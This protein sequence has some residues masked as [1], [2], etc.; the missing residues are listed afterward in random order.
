MYDTIKMKKDNI[1]GIGCEYLKTPANLGTLFRTAQIFGVDFIFVIGKRFPQQC[2]DTAKSWRHMPTFEYVNFDDFNNH[3]PY[4][5]LLIGIEMT[6]NARSISNFCHP[7]NCCY[8][9]G[10]EDHGL[11][12]KAIEKC[13][14]IICLPGE[15]SLNVAVAG[16][17]V[18]FDRIN[19]NLIK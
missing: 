19:K 13:N 5:T 12:K 10:A 6:E 4:N 7:K 18:L 1:C 17:I 15:M 2:S 8:L 16:S 3:R 14:E 11:S 9:L